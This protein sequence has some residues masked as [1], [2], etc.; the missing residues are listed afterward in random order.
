M[1]HSTTH[2][3]PFCGLRYI[4]AKHRALNPTCSW[5]SST[6][7]SLN[8]SD[9]SKNQNLSR[10]SVSS[11][12]SSCNSSVSSSTT[13]FMVKLTTK[14][15]TVTE[16]VKVPKTSIAEIMIAVRTITIIATARVK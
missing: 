1:S 5:G 8:Q 12:N 14:N 16:E 6:V 2:S 9:T 7:S 13:D 4:T 10:S 11:G 15:K 3:K